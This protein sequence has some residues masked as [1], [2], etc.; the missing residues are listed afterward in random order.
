MAAPSAP[1]HEIV[2]VVLGTAGHIDH[3]KSTLVEKLTGIHPDRLKEEQERGLT[4]DLGFAPLDLPDGRRVGIIDV[5]GHERFVKNMVAGATGV[6]LVLFVIAADDGVMP[7]TREHLEI[8]GLLGLAHGIVVVTKIDAPGV[9][10]ELLEVL[11]LELA[12]L[13]AGTFLEGAP[14]ARVSSVTGEGLGELKA[15]IT[16][17]VAAIPPRPAEGAFRLPV[18]RVF[19]AP[20]FGTVLTGVPISGQLGLGDLV[21]VLTPDARLKGKVRGLQAYGRKVERIRAGH[22]SALNLADVDRK[23][24]TRGDVVATPGVFSAELLWEVRFTHLASGRVPLRSRETVRLH[25]GTA[26]VL[27]ELVI[28]D[29]DEVLPGA[30]CLGQLR[31]HTP[32]VAAAGDRFIL[33]RHSPMDTLGGGVLLGA[34]KWRLKP[35]KGFVLERLGQREAALGDVR[36]AVRLE[37]REAGSPL[38]VDDLVRALGRSRAEVDELLTELVK[39][40]SVVEASGG[41]GTPAW[42]AAET[43]TAAS[44]ALDAALTA[45]HDERPFLDACARPE[46]RTRAALHDGLF[47][48]LVERRL[49]AGTL[50]AFP[51]GVASPDRPVALTPDAQALAARLLA[52]FDEGAFQPPTASQALAAA[53]SPLGAEQ[54]RDVLRHLVERGELVDL[55]EELLLHQARHEAAKALFRR[56]AAKGPVAAGAFK[57]LLGSSRRY[58]IPLLER[59]DEQGFTRREGDARTLRAP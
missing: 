17:R 22:S 20:G 54:A 8:L 11:D 45:W 4:I 27:G 34:S 49:A 19:S 14:R 32:V 30:T 7:Q 1:R 36:D 6:D 41:K 31:L 51:G 28:L 57:D 13:L 39:D 43:W 56:E 55:G 12:D 16:A 40:G 18:Q 21:E 24:V 2:S 9:D 48:S 29:Q 15:L 35:R 37:L 50:R 33:R 53:A 38:R 58:V 52:A 46:L 47:Q 5:P 59:W 42:V 23:V 26:E 10:A 3:G 44:A 25:V